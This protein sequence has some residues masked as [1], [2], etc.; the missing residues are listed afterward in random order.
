MKWYNDDI[1]TSFDGS[2]DKLGDSALCALRAP[3]PTLFW[4]VCLYRP[5][6]CLRLSLCLVYVY[7]MPAVCLSI[8][9]LLSVLCLSVYTL[10]AVSMLLPVIFWMLFV[11]LLLVIFWML[12]VFCLSAACHYWMSSVCLLPVFC[13]HAYSLSICCL[14]VVCLPAPSAICFSVC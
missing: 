14:F 8:I 5:V 1:V 9:G 7:H 12:S 11:S 4:S 13:M 10:S 3:T 6:S 2:I